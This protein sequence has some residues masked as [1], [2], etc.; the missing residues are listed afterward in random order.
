VL[1]DEAHEGEPMP[2]PKELAVARDT[3]LLPRSTSP[4]METRTALA[5]STW[6]T[7]HRKAPILDCRPCGSEGG[8]ASPQLQLTWCNCTP[9]QQSRRTVAVTKAERRTPLL[10]H[11]NGPCGEGGTDVVANEWS[12]FYRAPCKTRVFIRATG[13]LA[14]FSHEDRGTGKPGKHAGIPLLRTGHLDVL[15]GKPLRRR[16][17]GRRFSLQ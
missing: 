17:Q 8:G 12:I 5:L 10:A 11:H 1:A 3:Q 9:K 4:R 16:S 15:S 14:P 7:T 13:T 6:H 2:S